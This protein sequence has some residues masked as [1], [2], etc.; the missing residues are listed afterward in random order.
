MSAT[1]CILEINKSLKSK[2][3]FEL[4]IWQEDTIASIST[5][6]DV[7]TIA[8]TGGGKSIC[9]SYILHKE[10]SDMIAL[11]IEPTKALINAQ[12]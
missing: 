1:K 12:V 8:P 6:S 10:P 4:D 2:E 9:F 5:G 3:G 7:V 11:I